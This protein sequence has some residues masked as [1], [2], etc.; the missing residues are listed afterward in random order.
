MAYTLFSHQIGPRKMVKWQTYKLDSH[1]EYNDDHLTVNSQSGKIF[2]AY[3]KTLLF[4]TTVMLKLLDAR[5]SGGS[6]RKDIWSSSDAITAESL[7]VKF[8]AKRSALECSK[9]VQ[10]EYSTHIADC[11]VILNSSYHTRILVQAGYF[12]SEDCHL[13]F[14]I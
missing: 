4:K 10:C 2:H 14:P 9:A 5:M 11:H 12:H 7:L 1:Y 8:C 6:F 13:S 3:K